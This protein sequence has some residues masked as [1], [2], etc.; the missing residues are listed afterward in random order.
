M[1]TPERSLGSDA[2]SES[3]TLKLYP[4]PITVAYTKYLT[5]G[6]GYYVVLSFRNCDCGGRRGVALLFFDT[7]VKCLLV[8]LPGDEGGQ[9]LCY[10]CDIAHHFALVRVAG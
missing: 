10:L 9:T 8:Q 6:V 1:S 5:V 3:E 2:E 4:V 7:K